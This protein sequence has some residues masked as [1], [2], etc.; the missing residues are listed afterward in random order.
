MR[1]RAFITLLGSAMASPVV[2][3][4][5]QPTMPV[6][7]FLHT[8]AAHQSKHI[9]AAVREGL[10]D[11]GYVEGQN[12]AIEYR[13]AD[14]QND[15]LPGLAADL[16]RR[17]VAVIV[18]TGG[19]VSARAAKAATAT[20]PIVFASGADPVRAGLV[21]SL[22]RPGANVTGI[23]QLTNILE[24]KRLEMLH[25]AVPDASGIAMLVNPKNVEAENQSKDV[26]AAAGAIGKRILVLNASSESDIDV[27]F[28]TL[29][30]Q[31]LGALL[32]ASDPYLSNRHQQLIALAARHAV[33]AIYQWRD[34]VENGG[35]MSYG[36][37]RTDAQRQVGVYVGRILK[38]EKP[39]DLAIQQA[40]KVELVLNMKT[41]KALGLTFPLAL[42][43][44]ADGV[45]E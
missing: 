23:T 2:A 9:V 36:T 40:V 32:V 6:M 43:G 35:L 3:R 31:R 16:V 12:L 19:T 5:Q 28:A 27:A 21:A 38:G 4:A 8:G 20:I 39:A 44:R 42:L 41:A 25:L 26:Q 30:E 10:S 33:P 22:S 11:A 37:D 13:W 1:R 29:V 45:I 14:G 17:Q 7:G 34:A 18:T 15:R 24:P